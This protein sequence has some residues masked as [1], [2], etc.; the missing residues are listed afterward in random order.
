M[1]RLQSEDSADDF[2]RRRAA[3]NEIH[4]HRSIA[5]SRATSCSRLDR[6]SPQN[7]ARFGRIG[8]FLETLLK[9]AL[10]MP[11]RRFIS[12]KSTTSTS[13]VIHLKRGPRKLTAGHPVVTDDL[14]FT[15]VVWSV[16]KN[17]FYV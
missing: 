6:Y 14:L 1:I 4:L 12:V 11:A 9:A 3:G 13:V 5:R 15:P 2:S 10:R 16:N 17:T 8:Q 7:G